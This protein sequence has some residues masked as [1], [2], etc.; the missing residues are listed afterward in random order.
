MKN[1]VYG[2]I[3]NDIYVR[4]SDV[5]DNKRENGAIWGV[6]LKRVIIS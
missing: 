6:Y 1:K 5:P 4:L 3:V 2:K